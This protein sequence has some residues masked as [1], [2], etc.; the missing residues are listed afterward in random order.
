MTTDL[1]TAPT[2]TTPR[3]SEWSGDP[4]TCV[5]AAIGNVDATVEAGDVLLRTEQDFLRFPW[6]SLDAVVGGIAPNKVMVLAAPPE[7]G[8]TTCVLSLM[9]Q[10]ASAGVRI[11]AAMLE[12][13]PDTTAMMWACHRLGI[14]YEAIETGAWLRWSNVREIRT[15]LQNE[16]KEMVTS[17]GKSVYLHPL[18]ML[19]VAN[20]IKLFD[21]A[22]A[23]DSDI[24]IIDHVDHFGDGAQGSN[25]IAESTAIIN[26]IYR[27]KR[28]AKERG[29]P[30]R[31]LATSQMNNDAVRRG[32]V[33]GRAMPPLASDVYMG[34]KKEQIADYLF[35][36]HAIRR[37]AME[38][39]KQVEEDV[40]AGRRPLRDLL[41]PNTI[42]FRI[43][44]RRV[45]GG[46]GITVPLG[47]RGGRIVEPHPTTD[48]IAAADT[49]P[50]TV[51]EP[52][53]SAVSDVA[54]DP[55]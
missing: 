31:V 48:S 26:A 2:P 15:A 19:T 23:F 27:K 30:L 35:G 55:F 41:L 9:D 24:L 29:S 13:S 43:M 18:P 17:I 36:L 49:S 5:R 52:E 54:A 21:E 22:I 45:G 32:G 8:K 37:P 12:Q 40:K 3:A 53:A 38:G 44:K 28:E 10:W 4:E 34:Q 51:Y 14:S 6:P 11:T 50:G 39:D 25:G 47:I 16:L 20:V 46:S 42:G 33:F 1:R 7:G